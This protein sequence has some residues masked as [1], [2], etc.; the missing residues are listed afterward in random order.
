VS[1]TTNRM[2]AIDQAVNRVS[3]II[4]EVAKASGEQAEGIAQMN[5]AAAT[6]K[7]LAGRAVVLDEALRLF[8][9][10]PPSEDVTA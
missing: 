3:T 9:V 7:R 5:Q 8:T 1:R 6:A 10:A 2:R 4:L